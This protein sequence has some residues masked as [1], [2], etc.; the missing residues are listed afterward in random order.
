MRDSATVLSA[1][2]RV[3]KLRLPV[4]KALDD[5]IEA[6]WPNN[7]A[8]LSSEELAHHMA[9]WSGWQ[10][11]ASYHL[12]RAE[13]NYA[14]YS[15]HLSIEVQKLLHSSGRDYKTVTEAKAA[16][17]RLPEI[18]LLEK[19]VVDADAFRKL[20]TALCSGYEVKYQTISREISRRGGEYSRQRG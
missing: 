16:I 5:K 12:A 2:E 10:A 1:E 11:Y 18:E 9:W 7:V 3:G 20:I 17:A 4:P 14:A 13:T 15:K 19:N 8:D 6:V